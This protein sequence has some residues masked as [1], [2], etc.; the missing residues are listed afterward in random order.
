MNPLISRWRWSKHTFTPSILSKPLST[1]VIHHWFKPVAVPGLTL[2]EEMALMRSV[3]NFHVKER[4][5]SAIGYNFCVFPSGRIYEGRGWNIQG[6]HT[7]GANRESV[8]IA[9]AIDGQTTEPTPAMIMGVQKLLAAGV[10]EGWLRA[11]L[12][13]RGHRDYKETSCPGDLVYARLSD[14]QPSYPCGRLEDP[15]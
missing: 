1:V 15:E 9:L 2:E 4:G 13:I 6:A 10:S 5:W 7:T 12:H 14:F 8:G 11:P 3:E